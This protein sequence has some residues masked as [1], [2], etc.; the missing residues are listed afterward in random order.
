MAL[1]KILIVDN[2][3]PNI[4]CTSDS[5]KKL[6]FKKPHIASSL[7]EARK[8]VRK[9]PP[10][11]AL[12]SLSLNDQDEGNTIAE[13]LAEEF[14]LPVVF[15]SSGD[16]AGI[17]PEDPHQHRIIAKSVDSTDLLQ[18]IEKVM[19]K[20]KQENTSITQKV[21]EYQQ[22]FWKAP[23]MMVQ[24]D[25]MGRI[26]EVSDYWLNET[27]IHREESIGKSL[28]YFL[29]SLSGEM[30]TEKILKIF[31]ISN[32]FPELF[33]SFNPKV[34]NTSTYSTK[35]SK[36]NDPEDGSNLL[37]VFQEVY[38]QPSQDG[39]SALVNAL[40]D[41]A[42]ALTSTLNFD[43][44]LDQILVNV[45]RVVP[46]DAANVMMV[47]SGVAYIVRATGYAELGI[48][49][50]MMSKQI[51]IVHE[52]HLLSMSETGKPL[53][54]KDI[55]EYAG[56]QH[57]SDS[58]WAR[59]IASAPLKSKGHVFGFLN[60]ESSQSGFYVQRHADRLQA[61]ADQAAVAIENAKLYAEVKQFAITDELTGA[62][63]RR[64]LFELGK[65]EVER[66]RRY[67]RSLS[68]IMV[69]A[70]KFKSI[71]DTFSHAV[72][73]QVL[74]ILA[75]RFKECIREVDILGRYGGDEF[76]ILLPETDLQ[77]SIPVAERLRRSICDTG[78]DTT[79]GNITMSISVGVAELSADIDTFDQL[80]EKADQA[81]FNAKASGS[82]R[83]VG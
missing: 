10:D 76:V 22:L 18:S 64:G 7:A 6:G 83:V 56:L 67:N 13:K 21:N 71:N 49:E 17:N 80:V 34:K 55:A 75:E 11:I 24:L 61:F 31:D 46:N 12:V 74:K 33:L 20:R 69:D 37:A 52:P 25:R 28:T 59:S 26:R 66:A 60:L 77:N 29:N 9:T 51:P 40:R 16:D 78:F 65:R 1:P 68:A 23:V 42:A 38:M 30:F 27:S 41:T 58:G 81:M 79:T 43:E 57:Q 32:D 53:A 70:D 63:N 48:E 19:A 8:L 73:D 62:Y 39:E 4:R 82:N 36:V 44:V 72:G 14:N 45:S 15:L 3:L 47:W 5:L 2:Q 54:V 35:F 50:E